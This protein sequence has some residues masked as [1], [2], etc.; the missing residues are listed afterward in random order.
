[1]LNNQTRE[2]ASSVRHNERGW[3]P[4]ALRTVVVDVMHCDPIAV[5][6]RDF[7][8]IKWLFLIVV[9]QMERLFVRSCSLCG[10]WRGGGSTATGQ[11]YQQSDDS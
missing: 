8:D 1:M 4:A 9:E 7:L 11:E 5:L 10:C 3:D 6:N 2:G